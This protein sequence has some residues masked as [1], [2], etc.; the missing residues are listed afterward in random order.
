MSGD[1]RLRS[2]ASGTSERPISSGD[3]GLITSA[4]L[5]SNGDGDEDDAGLDAITPDLNAAEKFNQGTGYVP[6]F[7]KSITR[8]LPQRWVNWT[9][10]F[11]TTVLLLSTF[12]FL[13]YLG[14][15]AL[16]L[17]VLVLQLACFYEII[18]I[19][20]VVY[21]SH[22]LP[23]FR[24]LSWYFLFSSNYFL[25]GES[26]ITRFRL[27]LAKEDFLQPLVTHHHFLSFSFYCSGIVLFVLSLVKKHY[28]KQFTLF[29]WTHVTLL[30]VVFTSHFQIY[31][32]FNGIIWFLLPVSLVICNDI[33]AYVFGFFFGKTPLI[34]LSPKKTWEGFVG[35][36]LATLLFALV[37]S[38]V[39]LQFDYFVCPVELDE[40]TGA[41]TFNCTRNPV[42]IPKVYDVPNLLFMLPFRRV[43]WY[44]FLWH[45]LLIALYT[46]VVG[47]FGGFFASGFKRAF[48]IKDF[49]DVFPGHGGVVDRFD[50]QF[51]VGVF[52]FI[53]YNSFV[54][55]HSPTS[56]LSRIYV[57]SVHEQLNFYRLLTKGLVHRGIL[58]PQAV[59]AVE[60][61]LVSM[62]FTTSSLDI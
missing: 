12:S 23:W 26:L 50:C 58:P 53:Y 31:N 25:F 54:R 3:S 15:L 16:V 38:L 4:H 43:T 27:L 59:P 61:M 34:K 35:G 49:G 9:V 44:P 6:T 13:V 40:S 52:V 42:F 32:I 47:P 45:A 56:L 29:G 7:I 2:V 57:L 20:L 60:A 30:I 41:Q 17:L 18:N 37:F 39:L 21:R 22:D 55:V 48:R 28:I 1:I 46:S 5:V 51:I 36:G 11:F 8:H 33:M 10:R 19:G 24:V 62:N 14:P